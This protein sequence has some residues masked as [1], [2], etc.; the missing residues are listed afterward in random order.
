MPTKDSPMYIISDTDLEFICP[1]VLRDIRKYNAMNRPELAQ[2]LKQ[3]I[4]ERNK[5]RA[6]RR[7]RL[8]QNI[9][10]IA[11]RF[12]VKAQRYDLLRNNIKSFNQEK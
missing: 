1:Y 10:Y 7:Y 5:R 4:I 8:K 9:K 6:D 2:I 3:F 11:Y 12:R